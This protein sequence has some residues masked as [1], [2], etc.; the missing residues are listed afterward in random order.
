[1]EQKNYIVHPYKFN[2]WLF[3]LTLIMIF[4]GLTSAY[5]VS[6]SFTPPDRIVHFALP[7][8]LK[9]NTLAILFS[10]VTMQLGIFAAKKDDR[11][12]AFLYLLATFV[13][14]L[15]F[16]VGQYTA[17]AHLTAGGIFFV[18]ASRVDNAVSFFYMFTGLH[19]LHIIGAVVVLMI[20]LY[21][22][23]TNSFK[24]G[25]FLRTYEVVGTF[26]HFLGLLWLYLYVFLMYNQD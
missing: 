18:D 17:F 2:M 14:G 19:G 21:K 4:G 20:A 12:R 3:I 7:N 5:I 11:N 26:W 24:E 10:S 23:R 22:T 25:G 13:L 9:I 16:L 6:K 1:M 8:I 15:L